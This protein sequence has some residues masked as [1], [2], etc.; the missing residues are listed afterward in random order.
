MLTI[1][2]TG[3]IG[4]GKSTVAELFAELGVPIIDADRI[5]H[6]LTTPD[7]H[8][9]TAI[10]KH[11]G[12]AIL[13]EDGLLDR[14]KLRALIFADSSERQWLESLLHPLIRKEMLRQLILL[15]APYCILV[16]PLLTESNTIRFIDRRLI[17]D[18]PESLQIERV[19]LR[20]H[21]TA[22]QVRAILNAQSS[23]AERL[24]TADDIIENT[25]SVAAL[26]EKVAKLHQQY[27]KLSDEVKPFFNKPD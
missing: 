18:L 24:A 25:G 5:A 19:S 2:L 22:D 1:G 4:S 7:S 17:V 3:G 20:D 26:K 13:T 8:A 12:S 6:Q 27:L 11:F 10:I 21:L 9:F 15:K 16:I 23:R 14:K